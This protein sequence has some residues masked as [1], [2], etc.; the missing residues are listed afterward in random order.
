MLRK[1]QSQRA[2]FEFSLR[3]KA[4]PIIS[5]GSFLYSCQRHCPMLYK[6]VYQVKEKKKELLSKE[7]HHSL[8]FFAEQFIIL[9]QH[10]GGL[11]KKNI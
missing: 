6:I 7:I 3:Q 9:L 1:K 11:V 4:K 5:I 10:W 8:S 2:L